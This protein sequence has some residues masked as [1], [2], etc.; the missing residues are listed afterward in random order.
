MTEVVV[1]LRAVCLLAM[2]LGIYRAAGHASDLGGYS[3]GPGNVSEYM[4]SLEVGA[5]E[6]L[7]VVRLAGLTESVWAISGEG[8]H[9]KIDLDEIAMSMIQDE[10]A[11][12]FGAL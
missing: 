8:G 9:D 7:S 11:A 10:N 3:E 2:Y 1:R 4:E 6:I 12:I 5:E